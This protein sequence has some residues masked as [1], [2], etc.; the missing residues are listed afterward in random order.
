MVRSV[1]PIVRGRGETRHETSVDALKLVLDA[2][3]GRKT[4][5]GMMLHNR[6]GTAK[7]CAWEI[8]HSLVLWFITAIRFCYVLVHQGVKHHPPATKEMLLNMQRWK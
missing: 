1:Q 6:R 8:L 5:F 7:S 2:P 3:E 4:V